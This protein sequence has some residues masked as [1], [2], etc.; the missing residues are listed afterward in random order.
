MKTVDEFLHAIHA[1]KL[2]DVATGRGDFLLSLQQQ[3]G[4]LG[5]GIGIDI[6][7]SDEWDS[8]KFTELPITF[9]QMDASNLEFED[10]SFD[11]VSISNSLHHMPDPCKTLA[12]MV[13]VLK[14]G[15]CFIL[16]EMFTDNQTPEQQTH[17]LLHQWWGKVDTASGICH[18]SPYTRDELITLIK[19]SD[20]DNW[21]LLEDVDLSGD[22]FDLE[23]FNILDKNIDNYL[24]K[25]KDAVLINEGVSL[26]QR[27]Q[28]IGF[29]S[30][31]ELFALGEKTSR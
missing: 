13:R 20:L 10:A 3:L 5:S 27:L 23:T 9:M 22:P 6:K 26:R 24:A 4:F 19:C 25:T 30:A 2:L 17:T 1:E 11:L 14:P 8:D 28:T 16:Y 12:E 7:P 15:G 29:Q 31:T 21:Q 18:R